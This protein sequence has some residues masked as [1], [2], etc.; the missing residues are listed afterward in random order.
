M[1]EVMR[2]WT[3]RVRTRP[4]FEC[5]LQGGASWEAPILGR[6]PVLGRLAALW[7]GNEHGHLLAVAPVLVAEEMDEV[8]LFERDGDQ[9]VSGRANRKQ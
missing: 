2:N 5:M 6:G 7:Q 4:P 9:Y 1:D 8:T 3:S